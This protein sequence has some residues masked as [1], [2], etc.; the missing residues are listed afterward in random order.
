[1]AKYVVVAASLRIPTGKTNLLTHLP[2]T[3]KFVRGATV[4]SDRF[5]NEVGRDKIER[6]L[7][8]GALRDPADVNPQ[9]KQ[10]FESAFSIPLDTDPGANDEL[11]GAVVKL[12]GDDLDD[13][14]VSDDD[15]DVTPFVEPSLVEIEDDDEQ[16]AIPEVEETQTPETNEDEPAPPSRGASGAVWRQ[17]ADQIKLDVPLDAG[18][19]QIVAAY[20]A[21][22]AN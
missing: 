9:A 17:Y 3:R 6:L 12:P 19:D 16:T 8:Q 13:D 10:Q 18:R 22:Q 14:E 1:M 11:R 5:D 20:D 21:R 2:D 4:D 15:R 7:H